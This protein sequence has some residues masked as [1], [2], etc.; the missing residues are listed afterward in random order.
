MKEV[1]HAHVTRHTLSVASITALAAI[2]SAC[3]S[4]TVNNPTPAATTLTA[5]VGVQSGVVGKTLTSPITVH[6]VD[7]SG[8]PMAGVVIT[9]SVI[10]GGGTLD[11][12]TSTTNASGDALVNWTLGT[13]AGSDT[14]KAV[15]ANGVTAFVAETATADAAANIAK[16]SGDLQTVSVG[17]TAAPLVVKTVDQYGNPVAGVTVNWSVAGDGTLS[18]AASTSDATGLAEVTLTTGATPETYIV[19]ASETGMTSAAF[20]VTGD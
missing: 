12:A 2:A 10:A 14:L 19:T 1:M 13:T 3:G 15:T 5:T 18:A 7:Q 6:L 8:T 16:V 17:S 4:D 20:T 9:W 11:S